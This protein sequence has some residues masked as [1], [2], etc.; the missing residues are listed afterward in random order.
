VRPACEALFA[1]VIAAVLSADRPAAR[2]DRTRIGSR[3]PRCARS[4][5][6]TI[7]DLTTGDLR[8]AIGAITRN[9]STLPSIC[10]H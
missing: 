1:A 7:A 10:A 6:V 8:L 5:A 3:H 9:E 2:G 4:L